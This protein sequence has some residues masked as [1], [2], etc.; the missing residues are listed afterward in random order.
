MEIRQKLKEETSQF[1]KVD[2]FFK[3][4]LAYIK[5]NLFV[6]KC[7]GVKSKKDWSTQKEILNTI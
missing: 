1:D 2:T 7:L 4:S 6:H 3:K 5:K